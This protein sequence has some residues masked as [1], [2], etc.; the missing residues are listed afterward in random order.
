MP[1]SS[2][3]TI[4]V[5]PAT[6]FYSQT[7]STRLRY[8]SL[9]SPFL[10]KQLRQHHLKQTVPSEILMEAILSNALRISTK[11]QHTENRE[12]ASR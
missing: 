6:K 7:A 10:K 5:V 2:I 3:L 4:I 9:L 1:R 8:Q 12:K 11:L